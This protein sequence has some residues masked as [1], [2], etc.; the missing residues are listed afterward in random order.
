MNKAKGESQHFQ[1]LLLIKANLGIQFMVRVKGF[2]WNVESSQY[3]QD[4]TELGQV[5][6]TDIEPVSR[7]AMQNIQRDLKKKKKEELGKAGP[8]LSFKD[9][10]LREVTLPL[11]GG[12]SQATGGMQIKYPL[13][14]KTTWGVERTCF[15]TM[16]NDIGTI[17]VIYWGILNRVLPQRFR[18]GYSMAQK[19]CTQY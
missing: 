11:L 17:T 12:V 1:H 13:I 9:V 10:P 19:S 8:E 4:S 14:C 3:A 15:L 16:D 5:S 6:H 2:W 7:R 18:E